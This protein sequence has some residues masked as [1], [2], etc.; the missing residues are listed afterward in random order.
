MRV[1]LPSLPD[2]TISRAVCWSLEL[3]PLLPIWRMRSDLSAAAIISGPSSIV[4]VIGFSRYTSL[5]A[6]R[7]STVCSWCQWSGVAMMTASIDLS[8]S[9]ARQSP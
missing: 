3:M 4:S 6:A 8:A 2:F 1:I 7:A 5:P 9:R